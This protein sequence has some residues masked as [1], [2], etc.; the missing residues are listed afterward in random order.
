M[1]LDPNSRGR[2]R[3][4]NSSIYPASP[5]AGAGS[6]AGSAGLF[7]EGFL[8][9]LDGFLA[10]LLVAGAP[11]GE[12]PEAVFLALLSRELETPGEPQSRISNVVDYRKE[13][14]DATDAVAP[15]EPLGF[16]RLLIDATRGRV[17][18]LGELTDDA[19][20]DRVDDTV[21]TIT[22]RLNNVDEPLDDAAGT[23]DVLST[24]LE[25]NY[26]RQINALQRAKAD[27]EVSLSKAAEGGPTTLL[28]GSS[29]STLPASA[30]RRSTSSRSCRRSRECCSTP[31]SRQEPSPPPCSSC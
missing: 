13:V 11:L 28:I 5:T 24:M 8:V 15:V 21:L 27:S 6:R 4:A 9:G 30:S 3:S 14:E 31:A 22:R 19:E 17:R 29:I 16:R 7:R 25:T 1:P 10:G 26:A 2:T 20:A 18:E 12:F 23:I